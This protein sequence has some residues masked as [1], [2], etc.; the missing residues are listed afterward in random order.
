MPYPIVILNEATYVI[1]LIKSAFIPS[2][3][4]VERD[5]TEPKLLQWRNTM[6]NK[7]F[8]G[9]FLDRAVTQ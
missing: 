3:I 7:R 6:E 4:A 8:C 5:L 1:N 2:I 9:Y